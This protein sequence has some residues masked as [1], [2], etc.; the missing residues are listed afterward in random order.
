VI[1]DDGE[2]T[3]GNPSPVVDGKTGAIIL[4][5]TKNKGT[6]N[7]GHILKGEAPPRTV[8]V[9]KSTD[10]GV[11]WTTPVEITSS[12]RKD[13]WRWYATGPCHGIQLADGRLV[14]ACDHSISPDPEAWHAH[15]IFS[16]DG[17]TTWQLGGVSEG[18]MN[19]SVVLELADGR[20][21]L[22]MRNYRKTQCRA[23]AISSDRGVTWSAATDDPVLVEPVCQASA[24]RLSTE[25]TGKK[26]RVLF[27]NPAST[28]RENLTVRLSY[29]ECQTW[30]VAK[31]IHAGPSA[32]SDLAVLPDNMIV[33]FY[34]GGAE[35]AYESIFF[36]RFTLEWLTDG[37]DAL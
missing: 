8:W 37:K 23:Y 12:V 6:I 19:E 29:D 21:Y 10:D 7:E 36:A 26:N 35:K 17:G 14:I 31:A 30:A 15:A 2:D 27:S 4:V 5:F 18:K 28:H 1:I 3:C 33:C 16:D 25:K 20:L 11:S 34:E 24:V 13:D 22:N 32:Y 9:T